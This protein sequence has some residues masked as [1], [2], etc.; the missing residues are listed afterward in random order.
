MLAE[1]ELMARVSDSGVITATLL[2]GVCLPSG[3]LLLGMVS[4]ARI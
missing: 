1:A 2:L 3:F 4:H